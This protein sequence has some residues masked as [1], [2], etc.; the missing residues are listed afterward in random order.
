MTFLQPLC[1]LF[2]RFQFSILRAPC[3]GFSC[4]QWIFCQ[5]SWEESLAFSLLIAY[6]W[7]SISLMISY[8]PRFLQLFYHTR[9]A[10]NMNGTLTSLQA[11]RL[12][13]VQPALLTN[14]TARPKHRGRW[15]PDPIC[16]AFHSTR[17]IHPWARFFTRLQDPAVFRTT[18]L[19]E[20]PKQLFTYVHLLFLIQSFLSSKLYIK[21]NTIKHPG[22]ALCYRTHPSTLRQVSPC[23]NLTNKT[24]VCFSS[25]FLIVFFSN[26]LRTLRKT[27]KKPRIPPPNA[28]GARS[29]GPAVGVRRIDQD[30]GLVGSGALGRFGAS[31]AF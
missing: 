22:L 7:L 19:A 25:T 13:F 3:Y 12:P 26:N 28:Y 6:S 8:P 18:G 4:W 20:R 16:K 31:K 5:T 9:K 1:A 10:Q 30:E 27:M 14:T 11:T 15:D 21:R 29:V 17:C 23:K 2:W 24:S